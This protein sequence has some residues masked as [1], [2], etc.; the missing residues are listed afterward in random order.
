MA[1]ESMH[2]D[3]SRP[4]A[5]RLV[6]LCTVLALVAIAGAAFITLVPL[7]SVRSEMH[8]VGA[9]DEVVQRITDLQSA[10]ADW[11]VYVEPRFAQFSAAPIKVD[12]V[13]LASGSGLAQAVDAATTAATGAIGRDTGLRAT[14]TSRAITDAHG[15]FV[16]ALNRL[17]PLASGAPSATIR[18]AVAAE[19]S[20]YNGFVT[21]TTR[22]LGQARD[23]S[24][25]DRAEGLEHLAN[26]RAV[27]LGLEGAAVVVVSLAGVVL[28]RRAH[29]RE[30]RDRGTAQRRTFEAAMQHALEM[31][32]VENDVYAVLREALETSVPRLRVEMLV[33]DSGPGHFRQTLDTRPSGGIDSGCGVV[34]PL[35]CPATRR[36]NTVVFATSRALDACPYLKDRP[37]GACSAACVSVGFTGR[38]VGVV[39]AT[40]PDGNPPRDSEIRYLEITSRRASERISMFRALEDSEEQARVDPLTRLWNRR[41]L[42][43][44]TRE[45]DRRGTPYSLAYGDIDHFKDLNDTFG[46]ETGDHALR[47]FSR[48]VRDSIRPEDLAARYGGEEFVIVLPGC[49][50]DAAAAVLTRLRER[51]ARTL[52][53]ANLPSFTVSF[54]I[55]ASG[56][57]NTFDDVVRLADRALL[58]AKAE[59][60]NRIVVATGP[61][62]CAG[63][64]PEPDAC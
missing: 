57:A 46:H 3:D 58:A 23:Q 36:S 45:L 37:G 21:I 38:A 42:E 1:S 47:L 48:V 13:D 20:A 59:G 63:G 2:P 19:R 16:A 41:T 61:D 12:P 4:R 35:D 52:A 18:A 49:E 53:S 30:R 14:A 29:R 55:A 17:A 32:K 50:T 34:S 10:V 22:A 43:Q 15:K 6:A 60:R 25:R 56:G 44:H 5:R 33:A 26:G 11:Q 64:A 24:A 9:D 28:A 7:T 27:A 51:L 8:Q 39:H 40:A 62:R 54:G 31:S